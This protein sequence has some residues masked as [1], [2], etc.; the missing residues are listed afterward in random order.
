MK[1][2]LVFGILLVLVNHAG[3]TERKYETFRHAYLNLSYCFN[4]SDY[5]PHELLQIKGLAIALNA[6][7]KRV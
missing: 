7:I 2:L 1:K 4:Y 3:A 6:H 5:N